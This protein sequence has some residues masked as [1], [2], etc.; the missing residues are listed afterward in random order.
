MTKIELAI[1]LVGWVQIEN[2][3]FFWNQC[4]K[5]HL[6]TLSTMKTDK[7]RHFW[8]TPKLN[9]K[10]FLKRRSEKNNHDIQV[11]HAGCPICMCMIRFPKLW[12]FRS[13]SFSRNWIIEFAGVQEEFIKEYHNAFD[14]CINNL[15]DRSSPREEL[16]LIACNIEVRAGGVNWHPHNIWLK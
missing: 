6:E 11:A 3:V 7:I 14:C 12:G 4:P 9:Q 13:D 5:A 15:D 1:T 2:K 10:P 16:L 8:K